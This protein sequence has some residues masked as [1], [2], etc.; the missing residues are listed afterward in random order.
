M[1][2]LHVLELFLEGKIDESDE[3]TNLLL[4]AGSNLK[5]SEVKI[6]EDTPSDKFGDGVL[7]V[8]KTY[9]G[10]LIWGELGKELI[11]TVISSLLSSDKKDDE[12]TGNIKITSEKAI[13][14]LE[15][16]SE[17]IIQSDLDENDEETFLFIVRENPE[18]V[19]VEGLS[20]ILAKHKIFFL[21]DFF[22]FKG[23]TVA[24]LGSN[25]NMFIGHIYRNDMHFSGRIDIKKERPGTS[26]YIRVKREKDKSVSGKW[27]QRKNDAVN[28]IDEFYLQLF[29]SSAPVMLNGTVTEGQM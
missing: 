12:E 11:N 13:A 14:A 29:L 26:S 17:L 1:I 4:S 19:D 28:I 6:H 18:N 16:A 23:E 2:V 27:T 7:P 21:T 22:N 25:P 8:L 9:K 10:E 20:D 3:L 24:A 15:Y 5:N